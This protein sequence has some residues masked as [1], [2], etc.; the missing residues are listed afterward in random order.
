MKNPQVPIR[1]IVISF[2]IHALTVAIFYCLFIAGWEF[3][4]HF[5]NHATHGKLSEGLGSYYSFIL[6]AV[7][8]L[9]LT[10]IPWFKW[11]IPLVV[12]YAALMFLQWFGLPPCWTPYRFLYHAVLGTALMIFTE[13]IIKYIEKK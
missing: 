9:I 1:N 13:V 5:T 11:K 3:L 2:I 6:F 10:F 7:V 4:E 8:E 12:L